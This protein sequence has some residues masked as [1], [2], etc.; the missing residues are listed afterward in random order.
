[1][2]GIYGYLAKENEPPDI[3]ILSRIAIATQSR[4][5]HACGLAWV[6]DQGLQQFK[7]AGAVT[8]DLSDLELVAKARVVIGH[9][10]YATHGSPKDNRNNHPHP[11]GNGAIVHNGVVDNFRELIHEYGLNPE[12]ECD[13]EVI[14]LLIQEV[15][16]S[17]IRR[18]TR[19]I[20]ETSGNLAIMGLWNNPLRM[21]IAKRGNP[22]SYT[23]VDGGFYFASERGSLP[24]N[25]SICKENKAQVCGYYK[26]KLGFEQRDL[27][28]PESYHRARHWNSYS[29][30][31]WGLWGGG[32]DE[33][34]A[35]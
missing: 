6:D 15:R 8:D 3:Q 13:S 29:T 7:R 2:C 12:T 18:V 11:S 23:E 14:G 19:A 4:G 31:Q 22:L 9:T 21:V 17:L 35:L 1:M 28:E 34:C 30:E 25:P 10:R 5:K 32:G 16:G 24:G 26:G 33:A 27:K 20:N